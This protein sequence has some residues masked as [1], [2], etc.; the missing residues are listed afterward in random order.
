[1][2][3]S[4]VGRT[5]SGSSSSLPPPMV[6]TAHSGA[7]PSMWSASFWIIDCGMNRGK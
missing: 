2:I 4:L 6:T 3:A 5:Y 7:N 1:M